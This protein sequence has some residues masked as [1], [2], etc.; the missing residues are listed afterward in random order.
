MRTAQ[1]TGM[2]TLCSTTDA[3]STLHGPWRGNAAVEQDPDQL[4]VGVVSDW[5]HRRALGETRGVVELRLDRHAALGIQVPE[6]P[7]HLRHRQSLAMT[8]CKLKAAFARP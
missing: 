4:D 3:I 2:A 7:A 8:P 6:L 1:P 5:A